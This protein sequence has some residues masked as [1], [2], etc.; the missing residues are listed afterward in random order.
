MLARQKGMPERQKGLPERQKGL[1]ERQ[2]G[3][4]ERQKGLPE[5]EKGLPEW[6]KGLPA[7][8]KGLPE[9]EKSM[10]EWKKGMP[11]W[12]Y[13]FKK[14]RLGN[15]SWRFLPKKSRSMGRFR[16][17]W[18]LCRWH[19]PPALDHPLALS[20]RQRGDEEQEREQEGG[21]SDQRFKNIG[22]R[23]RGAAG[24]PRNRLEG[25]FGA[26]FRLR[27]LAGAGTREM[28]PWSEFCNLTPLPPLQTRNYGLTIR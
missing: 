1:P 13:L 28:K 6:E 27:S 7:R 20:G 25:A 24:T 9:W 22:P 26:R 19:R 17:L 18:Q 10:P 23:V 5:W 3:L 21:A 4:P 14:F 2:K 16:A 8:Q 15:K 12:H 11:F